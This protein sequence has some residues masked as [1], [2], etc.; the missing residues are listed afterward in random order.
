MTNRVSLARKNNVQAGPVPPREIDKQ[1]CEAF[2]IIPHRE[3]YYYDW[4]DT[5]GLALARGKSFEQIIEEC[6]DNIRQYPDS[7]PYYEIKIRIVEHL[8]EHYTSDTEQG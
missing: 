2:G 3:N 4:I 7:G 1:M 8:R 6:N 5:I